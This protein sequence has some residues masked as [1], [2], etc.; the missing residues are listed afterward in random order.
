MDKVKK[1]IVACVSLLFSAVSLFSFSACNQPPDQEKEKVKFSWDMSALTV[2]IERSYAKATGGKSESVLDGTV[3]NDI[4]PSVNYEKIQFSLP[5]HRAYL[6]SVEIESISEFCVE[7][8]Y[9]DVIGEY[10]GNGPYRILL[11]EFNAT[12]HELYIMHS[13]DYGFRERYFSYPST[14]NSYMIAEGADGRLLC[15]TGSKYSIANGLSVGFDTVPYCFSMGLDIGFKE[16][17][18]NL[19]PFS[20]IEI[21]HDGNW[22]FVCKR[23]NQVGSNENAYRHEYTVRQDSIK[24]YEMHD[25]YLVTDLVVPA[26]YT[27]EEYEYPET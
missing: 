16:E 4:I 27:Q 3:L 9:D 14:W 24:T 17:Y 7:G 1:L 11:A 5:F 22:S 13:S 2:A 26:W 23:D 12:I 20:K 19:S 21:I 18:S 8:S 25:E 6:Y 10:C 15:A